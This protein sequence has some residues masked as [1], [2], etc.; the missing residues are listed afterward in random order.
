MDQHELHKHVRKIAHDVRTPITTI[1]GFADLLS[2]DKALP[3][4]TRDIAA[5]IVIET[6][7]LSKMLEAFFDEL[8]RNPEAE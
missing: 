5:T 7:R 6:R 1:A 3:E 2:E 8:N 4:A